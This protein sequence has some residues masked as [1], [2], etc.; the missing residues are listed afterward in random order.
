LN[1]RGLKPLFVFTPT[2]VLE[3]FRAETGVS[4]VPD[5]CF[6]QQELLSRI[7]DLKALSTPFS[8][9]EVTVLSI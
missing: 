1:E 3:E 9:K 5:I 8:M 6:G 2:V 4:H 7:L